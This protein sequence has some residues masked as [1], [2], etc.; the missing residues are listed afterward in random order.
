MSV[1][2]SRSIESLL[3]RDRL[4]VAVALVLVVCLSWGYVL[5]GAG[6][7][8]SGFEMTRHTLMDMDMS[9][10]AAWDSNYV[11]L[12]FFMWWIMMIAMML[13]STTPVILLAAAL[14]RRSNNTR[15]PYGSTLSFATGYLLAWAGFSALA[16]GIQWL[17]QHAELI[18]GV[19]KSSSTLLSVL[20]LLLAGAWQFTAWKYA[21][22]AHCRGPVEYLSAHYRPGNKGALIMGLNHGLYC[23]GCCWFLMVLLFVG[24]VMNLYWITGLAVYVWAEKML[25]AGA[26]IDRMMGVVLIAWGAV[27]LT[28]LIATAS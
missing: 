28:T 23:L 10:L 17:L 15:P 7:G 21:C 18:S 1:N 25:P 12:M 22:M 3:R 13:P 26:R 24:G 16:V 8:M 5:A 20:L 6:M 2:L 14:N 27:L 4:V 11:V 19:L 9:T